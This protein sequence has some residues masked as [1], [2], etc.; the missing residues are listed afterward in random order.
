MF[1]N[2]GYCVKSFPSITQQVLWI[3]EALSVTCMTPVTKRRIGI[4]TTFQVT[5]VVNYKSCLNLYSVNE[6]CN[7]R[8]FSMSLTGL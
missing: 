2:K 1:T 8:S 4:K 6:L 3:E 5:D 7:G